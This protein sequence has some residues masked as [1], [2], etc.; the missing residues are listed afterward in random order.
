MSAL[1]SDLDEFRVRWRLLFLQWS[2]AR[3]SWRYSV[4]DRFERTVW[5]EFERTVPETID[6]LEDVEHVASRIERGLS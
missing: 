1:Q 3:E 5:A 4:G 2:K 6:S